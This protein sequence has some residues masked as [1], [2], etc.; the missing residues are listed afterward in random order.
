[1]EVTTSDVEGGRLDGRCRM[2]GGGEAIFTREGFYDGP[3][4]MCCPAP[5]SVPEI[6][7]ARCVVTE[8]RLDDNPRCLLSAGHGGGHHYEVPLREGDQQEARVAVN[9][10]S[11]VSVLI[12]RYA[13]AAMQDPEQCPAIRGQLLEAREREWAAIRADERARLNATYSVR[14]PS[15]NYASMFPPQTHG[16]GDEARREAEGEVTRLRTLLLE[17]CRWLSSYPPEDPSG[18]WSEWWY[19]GDITRLDHEEHAAEGWAARPPAPPHLL[20]DEQ[21]RE[22]A[23]AEADRRYPTASNAINVVETRRQDFV[24][25]FEWARAAL[26]A[27]K[28]EN[29]G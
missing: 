29:G 25:G 20:Q 1:V 14:V 4:P 22:R 21:G 10:S 12:E 7:E 26:R 15:G 11:Y 6:K 2:C 17:A 9:E 16:E 8:T 13:S 18:E 3:C 23:E 19:L 5:S 24:D 28:G 27:M